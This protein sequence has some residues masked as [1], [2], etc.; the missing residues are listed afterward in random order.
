MVMVMVNALASQERVIITQ[1]GTLAAQTT[2]CFIL[3]GLFAPPSQF[4]FEIFHS[5]L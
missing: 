5:K 4:A 2:L 1:P 3:P